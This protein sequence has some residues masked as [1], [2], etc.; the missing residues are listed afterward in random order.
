MKTSGSYCHK[1]HPIKFFVDSKTKSTCLEKPRLIG[2]CY[3]KCLEAVS[4]NI[5]IPNLCLLRSYIRCQPVFD[6]SRF[7]KCKTQYALFEE[8]VNWVFILK[9][10]FRS[11][12]KRRSSWLDKFILVSHYLATLVLENIQLQSLSLCPAK[13]Y[14]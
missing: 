11:T 8:L 4:Y 10:L 12:Q 6:Y 2:F 3:L 7:G 9:I 1:C 5:L 13:I 14:N